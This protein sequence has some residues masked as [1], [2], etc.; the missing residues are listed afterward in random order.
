MRELPAGAPALAAELRQTLAAWAAQ[1][2]EAVQQLWLVGTGAMDPQAS[3]YLAY[4]TGVP[5]EVLG[6]LNLVGVPPL[7]QAQLPRYAKAI[8][9]ALGLGP[10]PRDLDLRQGPLE[11]RHGY[12][13]LKE[14]MPLLAGL[15]AAI[16]ISVLF[17]T[18]A[19]LRVLERER[20]LLESALGTVSKEVLGEELTTPEAVM[21]RLG[22]R[23]D[24]AVGDPMPHADAFDLMVELSDAIP[25]SI[26][27][28]LDELD[29]SA[30]S[31]VKMNGI[32]PT[33]N[34][35]QQVEAAVR[36]WKCAKDVKLGKLTQAVGSS[37][38]KY[39]LEFDLRCPEDEGKRKKPKKEDGA[40]EE[41]PKEGTP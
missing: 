20:V 31:H 13:F 39:V 40:K 18:W 32:V 26:T 12:D 3:A 22:G 30:R 5:T 10:R 38:Q 21:D 11:R 33:K 2:Q 15:V 27:H 19:E 24:G 9:L 35:A 1:G 16:A 23:T 14:K 7:E 41:T 36:K 25:S 8:G 4:N 17:S 6:T 29:V 34:D 37:K 28:D